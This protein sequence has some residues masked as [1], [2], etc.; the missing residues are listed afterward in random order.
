MTRVRWWRDDDAGRD[1]DRL[2]R[3]LDLAAAHQVPL[4]LAVVPAWLEPAAAARIRACPMA[5]VL[6]HGIAHA[7]HGRGG[8]RKIELG[9]TADRA[10]LEA[11]LVAHRQRLEDAFGE[12]FLPVLVPP[13]NRMDAG[14]VARLPALGFLGLSMD[15]GP[16]R[17]G[18]PRLVDVHVDAMDWRGTGRQKPLPRLLSELEAADASTIGPVGFMTHHLVVEDD[19]WADLD[20]LLRLGHDAAGVRWASAKDVF[21]GRGRTAA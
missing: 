2:H 11:D 10:S 12:R 18:P 4:A 16:V 7:D 9:G 14:L 19:G 13:W 5:T 3:L 6:Q 20:R 8:E 15:R 21:L 17:E 1:H